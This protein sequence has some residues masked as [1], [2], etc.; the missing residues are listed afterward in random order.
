MTGSTEPTEPTGQTDLAE[1][2]THLAARLATEAGRAARDGRAARGIAA[3]ATKSTA[4]DMVTE[5][6]RASEAFIVAGLQQERP[7]DGIVGEEGASTEGTTGV[8]WL[9]DP[10]DGTTNFLY[11][12]AGWGVSI[13]ARQDGETIAAAVYL[14]A[15]DE[16][17]TATLGQGARLNG[18]P[19]HCSTTTALPL[20]LVATGFGYRPE[21]RA[22]Q[23][24]RVAALLPQVRDLRRF[25]AASADLCYAAAGR[26]DAYFEEN[27]GPWD[28]AAGELIAREAGCRTGG[29]DGGK[30]RPSTLLA[31]APGIFEPLRDLIARIDADLAAGRSAAVQPNR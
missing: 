1:S 24:A 7:D 16:L 2:L 25:G 6:D 13:A 29:L 18:A 28:I 19:I 21:Q 20:T 8:S 11:G 5:F 27:L 31:A 9:V 26:V 22:V 17:F 15:T 12:L 23:A 14:P 30:A 3:S 4:T 10:I